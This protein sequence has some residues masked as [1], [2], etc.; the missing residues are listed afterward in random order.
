MREGHT[1]RALARIDLTGEGGPDRA[2]GA[3]RPEVRHRRLGLG[4]PGSDRLSVPRSWI[5]HESPLPMWRE[6]DRHA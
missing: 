5:A 3:I 1:P 4:L 6:S 2:G